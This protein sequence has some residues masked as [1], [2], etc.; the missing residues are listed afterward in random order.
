MVFNATEKWQQRQL[1]TFTQRKRIYQGIAIFVS[2]NNNL[3]SLNI[4]TSSNKLP[5]RQKIAS[6]RF[7]LRL[8]LENKVSIKNGSPNTDPHLLFVDDL[9]SRSSPRSFRSEAE[10]TSAHRRQKTLQR[11][12]R[13]LS[14]K[15][16]P[17]KNV[18]IMFCYWQTLQLLLTI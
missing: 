9:S 1:K 17:F 8:S 10:G 16:R 15:L 5:R 6:H 11:S 13:L 2:Q 4:V 18:L 7:I 14:G 3:N 12:H